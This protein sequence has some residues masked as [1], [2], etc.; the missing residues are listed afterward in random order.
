[1]HLGILVSLDCSLPYTGVSKAIIRVI[2]TVLAPL[3]IFAGAVLFFL[4]YNVVDYYIL[5]P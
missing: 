3:Y 5:A 2:L 4:A 1:M